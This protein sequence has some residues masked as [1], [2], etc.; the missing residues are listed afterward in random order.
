MQKS[1]AIVAL[2][3]M[4]F[5]FAGCSTLSTGGGNT[6][7]DYSAD[8]SVNTDAA[9]F[10][11]LP[12][13]LDPARVAKSIQ[14]KV[15]DDLV[16]KGLGNGEGKRKYVVKCN[17]KYFGH[18]RRGLGISYIIEYK[19]RLID[20]ASG[21][22]VASDENDHDDRDLMTVVN[23]TSRFIVKFIATNVGK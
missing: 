4:S 14:S 12:D 7:R 10:D 13:D 15:V 22:V 6:L 16:D 9:I 11:G 19:V 23:R 5:T 21:T 3:I 2:I 20:N 17:V 18:K 1:L 8:V